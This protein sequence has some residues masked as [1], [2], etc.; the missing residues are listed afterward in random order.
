MAGI[1]ALLASAAIR[2]S[3]GPVSLPERLFDAIVTSTPGHI[4]SLAISRLRHAAKPLLLAGSAGI[5]LFTCAATGA[6]IV[7]LDGRRGGPARF[8]RV[9]IWATVPFA[10]GVA[11][12]SRI[13]TGGGR[14]QGL[15]A[16]VVAQTVFAGGL[17][18]WRLGRG[19]ILDATGPMVRR[20]EFLRMGANLAF[21]VAAGTFAAGAAHGVWVR[22]RRSVL[23]VTAFRAPGSP[24]GIFQRPELAT[25]M[26][27]E[28]TST[29]RFYR[30]SKNALD[31]EVAADAWRLAVAGLVGRPLQLGLDDLKRLPHLERYHTLVCI[32]NEVGDGLI[33]N[34]SWG[35][36]RLMDVLDLAQMSENARHVSFHCADGYVESISMDQARGTLLAYV[37]NGAPLEDRHG[38]PIRALVPGTYGMKNPKW[39]TRIEATASAE[40][41]FWNRQGWDAGAPP[42]IFSRIDVP[43]VRVV[44]MGDVVLGGIAF[45]GNRGVSKVEVSDDGQT[46]H[47]ADLRPAL[48]SNAWVLWATVWSPARNG[49]HVLSVRATDGAG[50][51]QSPEI[52]SPFPSGVSGF[53]Q[54]TV[55]VEGGKP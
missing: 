10:L 9:V 54:I 35:G 34:A 15:V 49:D 33:G 1:L 3:G 5:I 51:V 7:A 40:Q 48:S 23:D 24:E 43:S 14:W 22:G 42:R 36:V 31:P 32:S 46:W 8:G 21:A 6:A 28:V 47:E 55:A 12:A 13:S 38:F 26:A 2:L 52:R 25:L 30:I 18:L 27:R 50:I 39:I 37:M 4:E 53:H 45:A 44:A 41:G 20:R 19:P 16:M 11:L 17:A 29:P